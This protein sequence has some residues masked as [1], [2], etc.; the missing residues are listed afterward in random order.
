LRAVR[1]TA[2]VAALAVCL[3][4]CGGDDEQER[5]NAPRPPTPI[6]VTAAIDDT[7]VRVSPTTFGAGPVVFIISNQSSRPQQLTFETDELGGATGGIRRSTREIAPRSTGE[8]KVDPREGSYRLSASSG[9]VNPASIEVSRRR[10]SAQG[11][12]LLP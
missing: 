1:A 11:E 8:L 4:A 6:N 7:E 10:K 3:A 9:D 12:L 2:L 5:S